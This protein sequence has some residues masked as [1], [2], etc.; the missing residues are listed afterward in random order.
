[1][2]A[3]PVSAGHPSWV[4]LDRAGLA[5]NLNYRVLATIPPAVPRLL[6]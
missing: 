4:E 6:T 1:M 5:E 2:G 3:S